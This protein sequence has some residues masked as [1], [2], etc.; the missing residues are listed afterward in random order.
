MA[1]MLALPT[2][3][4]IH[5]VFHVSLLKKYVYDPRHVIRWHDTQV[6]YKLENLKLSITDDTSN[7]NLKFGYKLNQMENC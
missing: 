1:Y 3:I 6:I 2:H 4:R 5:D 7:G